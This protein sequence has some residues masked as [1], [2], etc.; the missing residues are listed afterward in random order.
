MKVLLLNDN[1]IIDKL[2]TLSAQ[3]RDDDLIKVTEDLAFEAGYYDLLVIDESSA[4]VHLPSEEAEHVTYGYTLFIAS[5]GTA[6]PDMYD[7]V[8]YKPFL[9]MELLRIFKKAADIALLKPLEVLEKEEIFVESE[10]LEAPFMLDTP[11]DDDDLVAEEEEVVLSI[12]KND[13]IQ[14][15]KELL[16]NVDETQLAKHDSTIEESEYVSEAGFSDLEVQIN[17]ALEALSQEDL[18]LTL[19]EE[20]LYESEHKQFASEEEEASIWDAGEPEE[21]EDYSDLPEAEAESV[22]NDIEKPE[23]NAKGAKALKEMFEMLADPEI[24]AG[25]RAMNVSVNISFGEKS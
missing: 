1:P 12:L 10:E 9:P 14:E 2:V 20:I 21:N 5:R 18:S 24:A 6:V 22:L 13:D 17:R 7:Q 25:L 4:S 19:D 3:K 15:V 11:F 23:P 8:L 16:D